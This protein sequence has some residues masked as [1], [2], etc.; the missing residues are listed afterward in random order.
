MVEA[1]KAVPPPARRVGTAAAVGIA[2]LPMAAL[3]GALTLTALVVTL[4]IW[5]L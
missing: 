3:I 2:V 5:L 1:K 4:L